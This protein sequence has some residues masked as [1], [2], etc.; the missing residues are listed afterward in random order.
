MTTNYVVPPLASPDT[1][2]LGMYYYTPLIAPTKID[3]RLPVPTN[4]ED[5]IHGFVTIEAG[6]ATRFGLAAWD[7]SMILHAYS[8]VESQAADISG[9]L[10]AYGTAVQGLTVM[11][12]YIIGLVNAVGG[13]K[14]P[15]PDV[16]LPRYR[17]ALTW[18]VQGHPI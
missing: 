9:K 17:S 11:G 6:P 8:D 7:L 4:S 5:T 14:L 16:S 12:W 18:R 1:E 3:T 10:M 2:D 13:V 15:N